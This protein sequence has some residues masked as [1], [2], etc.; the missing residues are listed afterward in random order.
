[1]TPEQQIRAVRR[2]LIDWMSDPE[3]DEIEALHEI[4]NIVGDTPKAEPKEFE[5]LLRSV[6]DVS[7]AW[8]MAG[9]H[10]QYHAEQQANYIGIGLHWHT[11]SLI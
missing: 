11:L 7:Q 8:T 3:A 9:S 6:H 4:S 2:L 5:P 1:M 10:P